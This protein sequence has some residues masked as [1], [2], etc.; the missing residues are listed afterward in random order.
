MQPIELSL[1]WKH[2]KW[3]VYSDFLEKK[4]IQNFWS[5]GSH[6][7]FY[8]LKLGLWLPFRRRSMDFKNFFVRHQI[9][10]LAIAH[11]QNFSII[12]TRSVTIK[13]FLKLVGPTP[14]YPRHFFIFHDVL[15]VCFCSSFVDMRYKLDFSFGDKR[16]IIQEENCVEILKIGQPVWELYNL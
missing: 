4:K 3:K 14:R 10:Y 15:L 13:F 1:G 9:H 7:L 16:C 11:F 12:S 6:I 5:L 8:I 2:K